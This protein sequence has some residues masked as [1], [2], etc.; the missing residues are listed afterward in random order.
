MKLTGGRRSE[1][2]I[3]LH[4]RF[5]VKLAQLVRLTPS[6]GRGAPENQE[7]RHVKRADSLVPL[8]LY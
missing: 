3:T 8:T 1:G 6:G 4:V 2:R 5:V 7:D